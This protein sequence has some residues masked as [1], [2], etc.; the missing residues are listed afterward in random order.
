MP[1]R[2]STIVPAHLVRKIVTSTA[3][4]PSSAVQ[5]LT[6]TF[7]HRY[8]ATSRSST[9]AVKARPKVTPAPPLSPCNYC[10]SKTKPIYLSYTPTTTKICASAFTTA[11]AST[12]PMVLPV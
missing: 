6:K 5:P 12:T 9:P 7:P 10:A 1:V 8:S 2:A 3:A 4:S 11:L